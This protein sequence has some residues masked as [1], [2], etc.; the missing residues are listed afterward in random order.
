MSGFA[1]VV[2]VVGYRSRETREEEE[3]KQE[4]GYDDI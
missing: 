4:E 3:K 2:M 1:R